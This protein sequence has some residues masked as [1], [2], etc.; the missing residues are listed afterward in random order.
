[1][2]TVAVATFG[3]AL[4][5]TASAAVSNPHP[6]LIDEWNHSSKNGATYCYSHYYVKD[7]RRYGSRA[8]CTNGYGVGR[9]SAKSD[10]GVAKAE[11]RQ[12]G[13][14]MGTKIYPDWGTYSF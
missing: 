11:H 8:Y 13:W 10:Y 12:D 6:W 7:T 14:D 3:V 2:T 4:A 1:M 9:K 5:Q